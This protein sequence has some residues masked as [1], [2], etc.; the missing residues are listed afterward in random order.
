MRIG[1]LNKVVLF[2]MNIPAALGAGGKDVYVDLL[3]T[4]GYLKKKS[5]F[6]NAQFGEISSDNSY[7]LWIRYQPYLQSHLRIDLRIIINSRVFALESWEQVNEK[8]FYYRLAV[9]EKK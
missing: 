4:K 5:G 9:N 1:Q 2:Q 6:K 3:T 8:N 7:D